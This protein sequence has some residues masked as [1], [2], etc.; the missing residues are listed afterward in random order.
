M[1]ENRIESIRFYAFI[2][3]I[4]GRE[5]AGNIFREACYIFDIVSPGIEFRT[6]VSERAARNERFRL[7]KRQRKRKRK[8]EREVETKRRERF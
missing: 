4:G 3:F 8:R 5:G 6:A 1:Q 2:I 7:K